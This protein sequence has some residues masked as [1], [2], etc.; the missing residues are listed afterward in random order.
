MR[1]KWFYNKITWFSFVFSLLVIWIHSYNAELYLGK[2]LE[3]EADCSAGF[4]Y[5]IRLSVLSEFCMEQAGR[6][7][8]SADTQCADSLYLVEFFVLHGL[9]DRQP[10]S[11]DDR[12][13]GKRGSSF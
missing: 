12:Y 4:F 3:M 2:S 6:K 5:D 7:V 13:S 1:D 11:M 10:P 8:E 9:C